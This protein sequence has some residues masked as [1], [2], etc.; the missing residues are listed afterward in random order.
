MVEELKFHF[1]EIVHVYIVCLIAKTM[2][3]FFRRPE[4]NVS[5][6]SFKKILTGTNDSFSQYK[7]Y[8]NKLLLI[9]C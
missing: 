6:Q 7:H 4:V 8:G 3:D 9:Y 5:G 1:K 2:I